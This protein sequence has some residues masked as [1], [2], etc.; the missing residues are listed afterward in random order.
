MLATGTL[1]WYNLN[2]AKAYFYAIFA[3]NFNMRFNTS[4][5]IF[6][7]EYNE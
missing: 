2:I 3:K 4:R 5:G 7:E 6:S 1:L